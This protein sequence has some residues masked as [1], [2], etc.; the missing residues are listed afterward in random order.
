LRK[1]LKIAIIGTSGIGKTTLARALAERLSLPLFEEDFKD[2]VRAAY[3]YF[4]LRAEGGSDTSSQDEALESYRIT[5]LEWLGRRRELDAIHN[6]YVADRSSFDML[7][8]WTTAAFPSDTSVTLRELI[9]ACR[10]ESR[11]LDLIVVPALTEWSMR[12]G[13]NESGLIRDCSLKN[14][15][16]SHSALI[17]LIHQF[18]SGPFLLLRPRPREQDSTEQRMH[19]VLE[20]IG[21]ISQRSDSDGG[22]AAAVGSQ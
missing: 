14:K 11:R 7:C 9:G 19:E 2:I 22:G 16:H 21:R 1:T 3:L 5:C 4:S 18:C 10:S 6:G 17:G 15:L 12:P 13:K 20:A 8:R